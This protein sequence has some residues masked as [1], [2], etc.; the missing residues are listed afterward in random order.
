M[1]RTLSIPVSIIALL[2]AACGDGY[3]DS[4]GPGNNNNANAITAQIDGVAW[5]S[6]GSRL[7]THSNNV[8]TITGADN[9]GKV[10][11]IA[12]ANVTAT[13]TFSLAVGNPNGALGNVIDGARI[14]ASTGQGGSGTITVST[15]TSARVA[16]TFSFT[17][18]PAPSTPA[19]GTVRVTGGTFDLRF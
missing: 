15:L 7:A 8:L 3:G 10:I 13:G 9:A 11:T 1:R 5:T 16:G 14:W 6:S 18:V 4:T 19:T 17:A 12:L 2:C